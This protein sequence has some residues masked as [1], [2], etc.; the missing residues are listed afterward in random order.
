MKFELVQMG[1]KNINRK[2]NSKEV[3]YGL[4]ENKI[5][6]SSIYLVQL[7]YSVSK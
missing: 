3:E 1:T 4:A 7:C 2:H 5:A 6:T